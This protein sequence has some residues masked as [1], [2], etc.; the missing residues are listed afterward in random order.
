MSRKC[1][2]SGKTAQRGNRVSH[3]K[4]RTKHIFKANIQIRNIFIPEQ[5]RHVKLR[6]ST[7]VL[8]TID[9]LGLTATLKKYNL[10]LNDLI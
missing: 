6:V 5:G 1:R 3:A 7:R 10:T 2:I 4:N 8:R 9:K